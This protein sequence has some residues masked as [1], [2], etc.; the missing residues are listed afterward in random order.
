MPVCGVVRPK[1]VRGLEA[2]EF[3]S[4]AFNGGYLQRLGPDGE[5]PFVLHREAEFE[6]FWFVPI[7]RGFAPFGLERK[8]NGPKAVVSSEWVRDGACRVVLRDGGRFL[9]Y[10]ERAPRAILTGD[11]GKGG[12]ELPF[13]YDRASGALRVELGED[14]ALTVC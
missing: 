13:S 7:E 4:Y 9:A 8:F 6:I 3:A 1:D 10:G 5:L 14:R 2:L 12:G 11:P